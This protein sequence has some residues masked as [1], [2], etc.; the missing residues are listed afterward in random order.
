MFIQV[1]FYVRRCKL[2]SWSPDFA[3]N[4]ESIDTQH[5]VLFEMANALHDVQAANQTEQQ[6]DEM[7]D[8]LLE[9]AQNHF[10][11]EEIIMK[12]YKLDEKYIALQHMEHKS[13]VYE[14]Q[15]LRNRVTHKQDLP[16]LFE[17]LARFVTSWL[18]YHTLRVDL[19]IPKQIR[20]IKKGKTPSEAFQM[21][22]EAGCNANVTKLVLDA[23]LH[24][25]DESVE[26]VHFLEHQLSNLTA[27]HVAPKS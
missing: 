12:H 24:L 26:R 5:K 4:I 11:D 25:W 14:I 13:F 16:F 20:L 22:K 18:I 17:K 6:F 15:E 27:E 9:Y 1:R 23:L 2:I 3:T 21:A 19:M 8:E 10:V 7:L